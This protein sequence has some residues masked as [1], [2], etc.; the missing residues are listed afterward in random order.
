MQKR[1]SKITYFTFTIFIP[2]FFEYCGLFK[3]VF[4]GNDVEGRGRGLMYYNAI[5]LKENHKIR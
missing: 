3:I 1:K 2:D 5:C 4:N